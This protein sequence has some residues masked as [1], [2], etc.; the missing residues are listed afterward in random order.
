MEPCSATCFE[1]ACGAIAILEKLD[2]GNLIPLETRQETEWRCNFL[3][4]RVR[5][6]RKRAE[7][8]DA[9]TLFNRVGDL[10]VECF[11]EPLDSCKNIGQRLGP[12]VSA[13]P[14]HN[15]LQVGVVEVQPWVMTSD[16][17]L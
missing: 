5:F 16:S 10:E 14:R 11:P 8:G 1:R 7:E 17:T 4:G 12:I 2:V 15:F 13:G 6:V 9:A 3:A